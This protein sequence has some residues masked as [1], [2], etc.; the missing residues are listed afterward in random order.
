MANIQHHPDPKQPILFLD[1]RAP[2]RSLSL[3][4]DTKGW[5]SAKIKLNHKYNL[6]RVISFANFLRE[7]NQFPTEYNP[8]EEE[9]IRVIS[10]IVEKTITLHKDYSKTYGWRRDIDL[11]ISLIHFD[12]DMKVIGAT[13]SITHP[14]R[15]MYETCLEHRNIP[16]STFYTCDS[17]PSEKSKLP[18]DIK[19]F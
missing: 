2:S 10:D 3:E 1:G 19:F 9:W 11:I 18:I 16:F 17:T 7:F 6:E 5:P 12:Q 14:R 15:I 8:T 13:V 4:H